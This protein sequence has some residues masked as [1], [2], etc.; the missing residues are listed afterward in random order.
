MDKKAGYGVFDDIT[1]YSIL[2]LLSQF[3][4]EDKVPIHL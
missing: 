2:F 4:W 1:R 3:S